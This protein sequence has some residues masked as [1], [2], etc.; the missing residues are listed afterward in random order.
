M[1]LI[2]LYDN[3]FAEAKQHL[4]KT[5]VYG[6]I[7]AITNDYPD[8]IEYIISLGFDLNQVYM[9]PRN[10]NNLMTMLHV[11]LYNKKDHLA[12]LL[13]E[14]GADPNVRTERGSILIPA[15]VDM[16]RYLLSNGL[17]IT[18]IV[19]W[20]TLSNCNKTTKAEI[21][22]HAFKAREYVLTIYVMNTT[23]LSLLPREII[24]FELFKHL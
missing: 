1:E 24:V 4:T 21:I 12:K 15:N 7:F 6:M 11:A 2:Y 9:N 22:L 19:L 5:S 13:I 14:K 3:N 16:T 23:Y 17:C 20:E 18:P 10:R 8:I